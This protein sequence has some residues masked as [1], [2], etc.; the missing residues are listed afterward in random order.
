VDPN[1]NELDML[2]RET[3]GAAYEVSNVLGCGFLERVYQRA[4]AT[5][6]GLRGIAARAQVSFPVCY[7]GHRVG[8]YVADF[9]VAERL[10][11]E[12][13]C[14]DSFCNE[15]LAQCINYLRASGL[16]LA[17]LMNFERPKLEWKRVIFG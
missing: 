17:L 8:D 3:V 9:V 10:L 13:K 2:V 15:H 1:E 7:K 11:V 6:L 4:L 5:E 14:V 12:I 16:G